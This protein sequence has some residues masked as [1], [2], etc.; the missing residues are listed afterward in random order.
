MIHI[1]P[2]IERDR[3]EDEDPFCPCRTLFPRV[4]LF[5][6]A[7]NYLSSRATFCPRVQ[8]FLLG[9]NLFATHLQHFFLACNS[10]KFLFSRAAFCSR[11]HFFCNSFNVKFF[12]SSFLPRAT[13]FPSCATLCPCVLQLFFLACCSSP[14]S[15]EIL[16]HIFSVRSLSSKI[17]FERQL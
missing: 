13:I 3:T 10:C 17:V 4:Q 6:L 8:F 15:R 1:K 16:L 2:K 11:V 12:C 5:V 7:C 9:C 14:S